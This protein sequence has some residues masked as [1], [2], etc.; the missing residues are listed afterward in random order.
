V[1]WFLPVQQQIRPT[2]RTRAVIAVWQNRVAPLFDVARQLHVVDFESGLI[3]RQQ[4]AV[5]P[6]VPAG[7]KATRL[8]ELGAQVLVC[9]AI[10]ESL[11]AMIMAHGIRV[12]PFLAGDIPELELALVAG[13]IENPVFAMPGWRKRKQRQAFAAS[14]PQ[15]VGQ[16]N[17]A[18]TGIGEL[19]LASAG[20][21]R[22]N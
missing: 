14:R 17:V 1:H 4:R 20:K 19:K 7:S 15:V 11:Q 3:V 8:V 2:V 5:M 12:F 10:S 9:G 22:E 13:S 6:D 21:R 16:R 18:R